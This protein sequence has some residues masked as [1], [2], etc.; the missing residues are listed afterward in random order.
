[1]CA[2]LSEDVLRFSLKGAMNSSFETDSRVCARN[3]DL[4]L[5]LQ[6]APIVDAGDQAH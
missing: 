6:M 1:M 4:P 3:G 5:L 2:T